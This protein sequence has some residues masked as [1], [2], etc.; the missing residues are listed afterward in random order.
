M[1]RIRTIKPEFWTDG[2]M[3]KI[4]RDARLF[5]VGLWNFA[6]DNGVLDYDLIGLKA[7][8][9]P[10]DKINIAKLV[11]E[12][13]KI[14]KVI[15]YDNDNKQYL[16]VKNLAT[17]QIIDRKRK[18][19]LPLPDPNQLKSTEISA[20]RKEGRKEGKEVKEGTE[21]IEKDKS[22]LFK[23]IHSLLNTK[24]LKSEQTKTKS[25]KL[26]T[27]IYRMKPESAIAV[28]ERC[29]DKQNFE[30]YYQ[31]LHRQH[32]DDLKTWDTKKM[33]EVLKGIINP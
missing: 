18:T 19:N 20:I 10:N 14:S 24:I 30:Y 26:W 2:D 11:I 4:S 1:A 31:S 9:F 25:G 27:L 8:I 17:H 29:Q 5:Y 32:Q 13:Q 7:K 3:L 16:F 33:G 6:D 21:I 23:Q 15:V 12:L 28:L 22:E